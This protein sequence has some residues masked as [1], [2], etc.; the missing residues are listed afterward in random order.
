MR[1]D[2][3]QPLK[4]VID[5]FLKSSKV[6]PK[7]AE[8]DIIKAWEE[9]MGPMIANRTTKIFV[10]DKVLH[11]HLNSSTLRNELSFAKEKIINTLNEQ[12]GKEVLTA[13]V[14]K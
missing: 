14:L 5:N 1:K 9:N 10:K 7:M 13:V 6:G 4:D 11:V 12:A 3:T 8:L 2:N